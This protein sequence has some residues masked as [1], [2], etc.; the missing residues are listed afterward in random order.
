MK[1]IYIIRY[2]ERIGTHVY[3]GFQGRIFFTDIEKAKTYLKE[4]AEKRR[5]EL[6]RDVAFTETTFNH[7][8]YCY[9]FSGTVEEKG[10]Y[11]A[12][13]NMNIERLTPAE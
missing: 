5:D 3:S 11:G 13:F 8:P 7:T 12:G 6:M 10:E 2:V 1:E 9:N 4:Q